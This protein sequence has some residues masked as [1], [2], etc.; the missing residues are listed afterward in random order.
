MEIIRTE[1]IEKTYQDNNIPVHALRGVTMK[2]EKGEF[3]VI[4]GPSGSGKTTLL[5]IIG[6]LDTPTKGKVYF[7]GEDLSEK[8]RNEVASIRLNKI[9][10][11]FQAYNLIPVLTALENIEF[12]MMLRGIPEK[13]R[14]ER[15]TLLSS[16]TSVRTK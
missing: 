3:L 15:A 7:E 11:V 14:H 1:S 9:G 16:L 4:A 13:E 8:G 10:F 2:V 6:G 5:N 12:T